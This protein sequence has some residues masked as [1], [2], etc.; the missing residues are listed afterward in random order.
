M[1]GL[2]GV[3]GAARKLLR[4]DA[5]GAICCRISIVTCSGLDELLRR[6]TRWKIVVKAKG[7]N[8]HFP[9]SSRCMSNIKA[10]HCNEPQ[11]L[12]G[13]IQLC[14]SS[15]RSQELFAQGLREAF[16]QSLRQQKLRLPDQH[17]F[18]FAGLACLASSGRRQPIILG[19]SRCDKFKYATKL[20]PCSCTSRACF[21]CGCQENRAQSR[22]GHHL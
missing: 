11:I 9:H 3:V 4:R 8:V 1:T 14:I 12:K 21:G 13:Q 20:S 15:L 22:T 2:V 5:A 19:A 6:A 16:F 7:Q 10:W 18:T 17:M